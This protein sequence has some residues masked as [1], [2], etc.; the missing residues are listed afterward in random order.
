MGTVADPTRVSVPV[1][2]GNLR[3]GITEYIARPT[4]FNSRMIASDGPSEVVPG[5]SD[6]SSV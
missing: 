2:V 3:K 1:L 5:I 6:E 4:V